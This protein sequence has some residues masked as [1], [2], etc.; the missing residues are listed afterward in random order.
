[1]TLLTVVA[2]AGGFTYR[3]VDDRAAVVRTIDGKPTEGR[4]GREALL[5]PGDVVTV[6]E[7]NF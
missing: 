2:L 7:R 6:L 3:A 4:V 5:Q 1:M